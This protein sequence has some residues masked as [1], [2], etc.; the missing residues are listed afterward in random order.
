MK[1]KFIKNRATFIVAL[2]CFQLLGNENFDT[3]LWVQIQSLSTK[4][5]IDRVLNFATK[6]G[7]SD[8]LVQ[9]RSR[10]NAA[11]NSV[12][13]PKP[14]FI[15]E[16]FDPLK[17]IIDNSKKSKLKIHAWLNM[18][19]IWSGKVKPL[20]NNHLINKNKSWRDYSFKKEE[21]SFSNH[22]L[23]PINPNVNPYLLKIIDEVIKNYEIDGIHLDYVRFKDK[24]YGNNLVGLNHFKINLSSKNWTKFKINC[25][26]SLIKDSFRLIKNYHIKIKL[27]VA[28]KPNILEAKNRFSQDC[29]NWLKTGIVDYVLPMNYYKEIDFFN[30]DLKLMIKRIPIPLHKNIVMGVGCYN[31]QAEDVVDKIALIKL[32]KFGGVSL[33][34][35]D[36][37]IDDLSWFNPL[38]KQLFIN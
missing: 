17:Y 12:F 4:E 18:Y 10:D 5:S 31:Q 21:K 14:Y 25:V 8:L 7:Y 38:H 2:F 26:T 24:S 27:S 19:I 13:I 22:F 9:V 23:S 6:N 33:F 16:N 30:R 28:V 37:H 35:F 36:N 29:G 15:S 1:I 11:Y 3:F 20:D 34:S 32:Y